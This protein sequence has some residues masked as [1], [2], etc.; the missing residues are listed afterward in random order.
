MNFKVEEIVMVIV[1]FLIGWFLRT[2]T[3]SKNNN[4][5]KT[6]GDKRATRQPDD[7]RCALWIFGGKF[8]DEQTCMSKG[9]AHDYECRG[10]ENTPC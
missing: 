7:Q 4:S 2:M 6:I 8:Q 5:V 3:T 9:D 10:P 1:A